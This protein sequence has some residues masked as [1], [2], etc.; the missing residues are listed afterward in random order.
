MSISSTTY[1]Y[2]FVG[3]SFTAVG[4]ALSLA[5]SGKRCII[6]ED[7]SSIGY[8]A[9]R[10]WLL[11]VQ[12]GQAELTDKLISLGCQAG[13]A[14][15]TRLDAP[16]AEIHLDQ[17]AEEN[18]IDL[19]YYRTVTGIERGPE[20]ALRIITA[21]KSGEL[22]LSARHVIV[23]DEATLLK[24]HEAHDCRTTQT[25]YF[26]SIAEGLLP[27][28]ESIE[29][30][31]M[32][33]ILKRSA[34]DEEVACELT[35]GTVSKGFAG[36]LFSAVEFLRSRFEP[37]QNAFLTHCA[38]EPFK[39]T[40][41]DLSAMS[42]VRIDRNIFAILPAACEEN[43]VLLATRARQGEDFARQILNDEVRLSEETESHRAIA[44]APIVTEEACD[45]LVCGGGT[46]GPIGAIA[47]ARNGAE[48]ILLESSTLLG[49]VGTGGYINIY[50]AGVPGGIQQELD[51]L[52]DRYADLFYP[53]QHADAKAKE[54]LRSHPDLKRFLLL[55]M[56]E[57]AGVRVLFRSTAYGTETSSAEELVNTDTVYAAQPGQVLKISPKVVIDSTGDGDIAAMS[58][59]AFTYGRE[60]DNLT[61]DY[62]VTPLWKSTDPSFLKPD[63][64]DA[65]YCDPTDAL[66]FSDSRRYGL[67]LLA[68]KIDRVPRYLA[69][70]SIHGLRSSRQICGDYTVTFDD[71]V[72]HR[73]FPDVI[74]YSWS[75]YDNH[76]WDYESCSLDAVQWCW[77]YARRRCG[78][79]SEV[80]YRAILAKGLKNI[81]IAC[82]AVS[83]SP[84]AHFLLR[85]QRDVMRLA[86]AAGY[87]AAMAVRAHRTVRQID[88]S[89][90]QQML[91][92]SGALGDSELPASERKELHGDWWR[93]YSHSF[94]TEHPEIPDDELLSALEGE[95][96]P[97]ALWQISRKPE[98]NL[99]LKEALGRQDGLTRLWA[100]MGLA[101]NG[102]SSGEDELIDCIREKNPFIPY[103]EEAVG[104]LRTVPLWIPA[105]VLCGRI[106][107]TRSVP[108]LTDLLNDTDSSDNQIAL[109]AAIR[110]LGA[111]KSRDA[112]QPLL[113]LLDHSETGSDSSIPYRKDKRWQIE[114]S[115]IESLL[116]LGHREE[117][118]STILKK[119][120]DDPRKYISHY[121]ERL[122]KLVRS[123]LPLRTQE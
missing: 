121:A 16:H 23:T 25:F 55:R 35:L 52:H 105:I 114:C 46:A 3:G 117:R 94:L 40:A 19:L 36:R 6:V 10:S 62:S 123:A 49:G 107:S 33:F 122:L 24:H 59:A 73:Q 42:G 13:V 47:A 43:R 70:G 54:P 18:S 110:A 68:E 113:D 83:A 75:Y 89:E 60:K 48:T 5:Q 102:D 57:E 56:A 87:A 29:H 66:D 14:A 32:H 109:I 74:S 106:E 120:M 118:F 82:R 15:R 65:G 111:I 31:G 78:I 64:F 9:C 119:H 41:A 17:I 69:I 67:K 30:D 53:A 99:L 38:P 77:I 12:E 22:S 37:L 51:D 104:Q 100:A 96:A 93:D 4:C 108:V 27:Y 90:L 80:P 116:S 101:L 115:T 95:N 88:V 58:G 103:G 21:G 63:N 44:A 98:G 72:N 91:L 71:Q 79:G 84:D 20:E 34:Y 61:H 92:N 81:L 2:L 45:V 28:D 50:W 76:A 1:D 39:S 8:E 86:E 85:M 26:N 112:V 97:Q 11:D 7:R